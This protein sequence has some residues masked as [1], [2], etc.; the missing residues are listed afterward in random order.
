[1]GYDRVRAM[2]MADTIFGTTLRLFELARR[3]RIPT[4]LA[5]DRLAEQRIAA[6]EATGPR[7]WERIA[8]ERLG[9]RA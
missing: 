9:R 1:M 8:R 3:E 6:V 2:R 7:H 5:G 4:W